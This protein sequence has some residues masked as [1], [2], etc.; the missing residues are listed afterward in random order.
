MDL[1][2]LNLVPHGPPKDLNRANRELVALLLLLI[3]LHG[4]SV[5]ATYTTKLTQHGW[6]LG[7]GEH[8]G[9]GETSG[10]ILTDLP[11]LTPVAHRLLGIT[12][13]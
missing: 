8:D 7:C 2:P 3:T 11:P 13:G 4:C 10:M 5:Q 6:L 9:G 12:G 1:I